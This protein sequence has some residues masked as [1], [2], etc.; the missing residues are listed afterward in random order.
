MINDLTTKVVKYELRKLVTKVVISL[1]DS[2]ICL[3]VP[4]VGF[5]PY[6]GIIIIE[7]IDL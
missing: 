2:K 6:S 3:V 1:D 5:Y 7:V 4:Q